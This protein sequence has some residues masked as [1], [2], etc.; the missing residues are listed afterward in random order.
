M[1]LYCVVSPMEKPLFAL[2]RRMMKF[3]A[4]ISLAILGYCHS[5]AVDYYFQA[6]VDH[7]YENPYNWS[8]A[9]PGTE[10]ATGDRVFILEDVLFTDFQL[11]VSGELMIQLGVR[12]FS[13]QGVQV[14]TS[15]RV[16]NEGEIVV[17]H[18]DNYGTF[19]NRLNAQVHVR[20]FAT[21]KD[22]YTHNAAH[23]HIKARGRLLNLGR[24]DN[25][26]ICET[27]EFFENRSEFNQLPKSELANR[28]EYVLVAGSH[29][30]QSQ[31]SRVEMGVQRKYWR[32]PSD[33]E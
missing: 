12:A 24:F 23:A 4:F 32:S 5:Y 9:Y 2:S 19:V 29:F 20:D 6:K 3:I 21:H 33:M 30:N 18:I 11:E 28:G 13:R 17:N 22:G 27:G 1:R 10:I 26:G 14:R 31:S 8:P 16:H 7:L 15:G 25:Y